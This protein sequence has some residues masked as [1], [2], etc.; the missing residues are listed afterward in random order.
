MASRI[1]DYALIGD[2]RPPRWSAATARS[3]GCVGRDS[4]RTLALPRC[5]GTAEHGRWLIAPKGETPRVT[6][7]VPGQHADPGNAV[8]DRR[9]GGD[10]DRFHAAAQRRLAY[11][12]HGRR[13]ARHGEDAHRAGAPLRLW[14]DRAV[15]DAA[16]RSR[17]CAGLPGRTRCWCVRMSCCAARTSRRSATSWSRPARRRL[18]CSLICPCTRRSRS[19]SIRS[20]RSPRPRRYW[21]RLGRQKPNQGPVERCGD[22]LADHAE[23][24]DL[25]AD[26]RHGRGGDHLAARADR[27][28]AQLGLPVLLAARRDVDAAR[29]DERRLLRGGQQMARLAVARGR[30]QPAANADH[31]RHRRRAAA[32][33]M[34]RPTGFP[35]TR[36]PRRCGSATRRTG[37]SSSTSSAK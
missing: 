4:I 3:T 9:R 1:E 7:R 25:R 30:R 32:H 37:S 31:V 16:R 5:L 24:A 22:A 35:A 6:R 21:T 11:R 36:A 26:R 29:A 2:L 19:R 34:G 8:R 10:A 23:G 12:A 17:L 33:R 15:G 20:M 13:R 28:R 14:R 27:R 18:S